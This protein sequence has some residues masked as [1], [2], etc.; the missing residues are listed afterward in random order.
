L[1]GH[2]QGWRFR[3][4]RGRKDE[5]KDQEQADVGQP[6]CQG[7][8]Q[9]GMGALRYQAETKPNQENEDQVNPRPVTDVQHGEHER[10]VPGADL[11]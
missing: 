11:L 1:G 4:Q 10:D 6:V 9:Q 5:W 7:H 3:R 8:S 2:G